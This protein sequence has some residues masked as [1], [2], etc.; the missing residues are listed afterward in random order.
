MFRQSSLTWGD[1]LLL[2][3]GLGVTLALFL[4]TFAL[5]SLIGFALALL[6]QARVPVLSQLTLVYVELFRNSPLLVQLF[7]IFFGVPIVTGIAFTPVEA[8][9]IAIS[10]NTGAYMT[11]IVLAA[12]EE[13]PRGQWE[14]ARS[15]GLRHLQAMRRVILPQALPAILPP[16]AS[17]A[18]NQL[19]VTSLVS[20]IGVV[21]L[22][23]AGSIL[24]V[25]N[26]SPYI[27]WP[28]IGLC[29]FAVSKPLSLLA[30]W[31]ER[32]LSSQRRALQLVLA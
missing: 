31:A 18:V 23:K 9:L 6:R 26:V 14:A 5:G 12:I 16:A 13:V 8:G 10:I 20:L 15:T 3:R 22:A 21:E 11:V 2:L 32:R 29:Y 30:D 19:H 4:A 1:G 17:L 28:L 24:N 7:L 27:V 25:R